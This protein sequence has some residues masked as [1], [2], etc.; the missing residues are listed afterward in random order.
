MDKGNTLILSFHVATAPS[1]KRNRLPARAKAQ[2]HQ[3]QEIRVCTN[4]TCRRQGSFQTLET[5][6]GIAPPN[7][8]VKSCGCLGRCGSG[9]NLVGLPDGI[10]VGH[11]GTAARCLEVMI[12]LF[13]VGDNS[14]SS[15]D[16]LALRK[17]ADLE[18]EKRNFTEA[19]LLLSQAIDLKPFGGIHVTF[20]CRSLV[21]LE[22]GNYSGAL[23]DAKEALIL[24]PGYTEAYICQGDAFLALNI[25]DLA[26]HSYLASL[27]IDPSIRHSK[28]FKARIT[29]LQ[30]KLACV[31]TS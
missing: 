31:N 16:A 6:S 23:Q 20:K 26:E 17:R 2:A 18:F 24:A 28:S 7:V 27:D 11:C 29:R 14:K 19:E 10:M 3:L 25:F 22:L 12:S 30:E 13:G 8:A 1:T 21:R 15:L 9:P 5:L 4:R